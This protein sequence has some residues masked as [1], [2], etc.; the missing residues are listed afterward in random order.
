MVIS[1]EEQRTIVAKLDQAFATIDQAKTNIEK[2]ITNAKELFQSKL[3]Q[4]FFSKR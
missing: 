4:I 1:L 3:N 2:N